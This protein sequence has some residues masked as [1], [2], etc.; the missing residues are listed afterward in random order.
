ME[1]PSMAPTPRLTQAERELV[2]VTDLFCVAIWFTVAGLL[3]G[4][5]CLFGG[6]WA[7][8]IAAALLFAVSLISAIQVFRWWLRRQALLR[9]GVKE[10]DFGRTPELESAEQML[11]PVDE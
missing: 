8:H 7:W 9:S 3:M 10:A 2:N 6:T 5:A 11:R 1:E 4:L